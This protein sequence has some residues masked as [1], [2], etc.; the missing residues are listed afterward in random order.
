MQVAYLASGKAPKTVTKIRAYA[1]RS[2]VGS[3]ASGIDVINRLRPEQREIL[4]HDGSSAIDEEKILDQLAGS[5]RVQLVANARKIAVL[6]VDQ[7]IHGVIDAHVVAGRLPPDDYAGIDLGNEIPSC[8]PP[9]SERSY[10]S[11]DPSQPDII[12]VGF[13]QIQPGKYPPVA[14]QWN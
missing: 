6:G 10:S 5:C 14:R 2:Y 3:V 12:G 9:P 1:H 7:I 13:R 8:I 11:P 4:L